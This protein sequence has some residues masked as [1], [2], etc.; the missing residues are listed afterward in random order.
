MEFVG[1]F[2]ASWQRGT[3][4]LMA[5]IFMLGALLAQACSIEQPVSGPIA[6]TRE[7]KAIE[8]PEPL[9]V[10]SKEMQEICL[11]V[12]GATT[13]VD[14][15]Q[16][17]LLVNGQWHVLGGE[18]VDNE[19]TKYGLRVGSLGGDTVCLYRAGK[20][21]TGPDFSPDL[22]IIRLRLRSDPPLEVAQVRWSS[23]DQM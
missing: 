7:W 6:L 19:Q 23:H 10:G 16:G 1:Q 2:A 17:R 20:P 11:Q 14:F 15:E 8:P 22:T 13:D 9:R 3:R 4:Q 18:A 12:I 5:S 21:S